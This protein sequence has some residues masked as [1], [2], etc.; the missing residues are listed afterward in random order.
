M[1][2]SRL[3]FTEIREKKK[4]K[5]RQLSRETDYQFI[6]AFNNS[7]IFGLNSIVI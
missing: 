5:N 1:K 2:A 7:A 6:G 4:S 3:V